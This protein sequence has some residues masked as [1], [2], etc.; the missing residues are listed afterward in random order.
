LLP[1]VWTMAWMVT[2]GIPLNASSAI[3]F[4]LSIGLSVDGSIHLVSRFQEERAR[5]SM[6]TTALLRAVHGTGRN[7]VISSVAL[8]LGFSVMLLS[9]F[10]PVQRFAE[11][12]SVSLLGCVLATLVIQPALLR[13]FA[14][15]ASA[16]PVPGAREG[17]AVAPSEP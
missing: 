9:N 3:I 2:R 13:L 4:S 1:Q 8:M 7:I 5:G 12:I 17:D 15:R 16:L 10:V 14:G 6:V 11:L